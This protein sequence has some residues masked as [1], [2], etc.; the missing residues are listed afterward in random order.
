MVVELVKVGT[1]KIT[2]DYRLTY[3]KGKHR[4]IKFFKHDQKSG[5]IPF[6]FRKKGITKEK[7]LHMKIWIESPYDK[8][9]IV[10]IAEDRG[11]KITRKNP[12]FVI[13]YGG[14]GT[15]LMAERK[16]PGIPKV[17]IR[18]SKIC[19]MC[20]SYGKDN[21]GYVLDRLEKKDFCLEKS[22]KVEAIFKKKKLVAVNEIQIH[23]KDPRKAIRFSLE[24]KGQKLDEVIG[25]G[26][27]FSTPFG[28][29]AYY[30]SLGLEPFKKGI[31][32]GFNNV[33]P[34]REPIELRGP[35]N[36]EIIREKA[37]LLCDNNGTIN[38]KPGDRVEIYESTEKAVFVRL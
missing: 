5:S 29:T 19:S 37:L 6:L 26:L 23:N 10:E 38:L 22:Q 30:R 24:V 32:I 25:D 9:G 35:A 13:T 36:V 11:I 34:H 16:F 2:P 12:D 27:I 28:S 17:P 18:N 7:E 14:D 1:K 8:S 33:Y 21:L 15:I 4:K 31:R 3:I 20:V